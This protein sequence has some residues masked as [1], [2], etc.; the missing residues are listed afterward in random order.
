MSKW[1]TIVLSVAGLALAGYVVA[2]SGQEVPDAPPAATPTVNPYADGI[3][4]AGPVEASTRNLAINPPV[5]GLVTKVLVE[6]NDAVAPDQALFVLDDR[7]LRALLPKQE[8]ALA[9]AEAELAK[10][11]ASPRPESL[12]PL[13]A[14][15]ASAESRV[16][17]AAEWYNDVRAA[18]EDNAATPKE[19]RRAWFALNLMRAELEVARARLREAEAGAWEYDITIAE[20]QVEQ[21]RAEVEGTR[22]L[23]E[24]LTVRSPVEGVVLKRNIE[25][26]RFTMTDPNSPAMTVGGIRELR[27]RAQVDEEDLP[28]LR[29]GA[30]GIARVRGAA[31]KQLALEMIRI[32]PLAMPKRSLTGDITER[33]DTRVVEVLFRVTP[34]EGMRLYPGQVVDVYIDASGGKAGRTPG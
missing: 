30:E 17:D 29:D 1:I 19:L 27:V 33:V 31:E 10:L 7:E 20:A 5:G 24:R 4:A 9:R 34:P 22:A 12:P 6:V 18:H 8:A 16:E 26:G 11:R 15:V 2:T 3:A 21:A 14:E 32:E 28:R 25:P 23:I 13:R